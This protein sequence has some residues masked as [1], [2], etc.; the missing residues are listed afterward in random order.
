MNLTLDGSMSASSGHVFY[1][2]KTSKRPYSVAALITD[3]MDTTGKCLSLLY[4]LMGETWDGFIS[5]RVIDE[6]ES[7]NYLYSS[8]GLRQQWNAV[9]VRL[10][11]GLHRVMISGH[12]GE[13]NVGLAVDSVSFESCR[14]TGTNICP[15]LLFRT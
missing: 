5:L 9:R 8:N 6:D 14:D 10:L 1:M 4:H 3:Y 15:E 7:Q 11:P 13:G 12:R 2:M